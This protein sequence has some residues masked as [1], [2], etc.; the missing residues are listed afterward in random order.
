MKAFDVN[1]QWDDPYDHQSDRREAERFDV[2]IRVKVGV[3]NRATGHWLVG[4]GKTRDLSAT[5]VKLRTRHELA[6]GDRVRVAIPTD[7]AGQELCLP[8]RFTTD[9]TVVR[10]GAVKKSHNKEVVLRFDDQ[11]AQSMDFAA[12]VSASGIAAHA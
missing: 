12:F 4:P 10:S 7:S 8:K 3:K 9:A 5:G 1:Q 11:L 2:G 6:E